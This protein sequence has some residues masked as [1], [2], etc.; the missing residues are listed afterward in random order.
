[1]DD[2]PTLFVPSTAA[3]VLGVSSK[4][5]RRWCDSG[6]LASYRIL[7]SQSRRIGIDALRRY[8][9]QHGLALPLEADGPTLFTTAGAARALGLTKRELRRRFDRGELVGYRIP[10]IHSRRIPREYLVRFVHE[11]KLPCPLLEATSHP[12][13]FDG[14]GVA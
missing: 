12:G 7:A 5:I 11:R 14:C 1:M 4:Q 10:A 8:A 13:E 2:F 9:S 3:A 6:E